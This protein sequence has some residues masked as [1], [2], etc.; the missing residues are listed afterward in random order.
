MWLRSSEQGFDPIFAVELD[1]TAAAIYRANF[2]DH[3][4]VG[5]IAAVRGVPE[6]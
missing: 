6:G 1:E 5:D 2:G 4:H 3:I